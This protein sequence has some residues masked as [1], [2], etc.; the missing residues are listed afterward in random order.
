MLTAL[1]KSNLRITATVLHPL[2]LPHR[3]ATRTRRTSGPMAA[4]PSPS[5][6]I[7]W[8]VTLPPALAVSPTTIAFQGTRRRAMST[9]LDFLFERDAA[10]SFC[11]DVDHECKFQIFPIPTCFFSVFLLNAC[12]YQCFSGSSTLA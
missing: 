6:P 8:V 3:T 7:P 12:I 11:F 5:L 4:P 1:P 9:S 10:H 2:I